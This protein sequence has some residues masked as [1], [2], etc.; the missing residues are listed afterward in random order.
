MSTTTRNVLIVLALALAVYAIPGGGV[1]A[2]VSSGLSDRS[3]RRAL[4]VAHG[5]RKR[6]ET[7]Y[8]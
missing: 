3:P 1:S 5:L 2:I 6:P 4:F 7:S 8:F